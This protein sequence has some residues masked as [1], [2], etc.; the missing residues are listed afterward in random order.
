EA[1]ISQR[2]GVARADEKK[3]LHISP[4]AS[5]VSESDLQIFSA[6]LSTP[7]AS[8]TKYVP[9]VR[10]AT[11]TA[12]PSNVVE[13]LGTTDLPE[14]WACYLAF[15][16]VFM[17]ES[18]FKSIKPEEREAL[19]TWV[20]TGGWLTL[21]GSTEPK[22]ETLMLG[23]LQRQVENPLHQKMTENANGWMKNQVLWKSKVNEGAGMPY[24]IKKGQ[25]TT[26]ALVVAAIFC[27]VAGPGNYLYCRRKKSIHLLLYTLPSLSILFCLLIAAQFVLSK[28]L[29]RTG[30]SV[31][32]TL[33]DEA[34]N[35]GITLSKH[36]FYSG[37]YPLRGFH[38]NAQTAL[39]FPHP[40]EERSRGYGNKRSF[41]MDVS[42][43]QH[44]KNGLFVPNTTFDYMTVL[45][46]KTRE[47][48]VL[49]EAALTVMNGFEKVITQLL[50]KVGDQY[51]E[52]RD[53]Q[54]GAK[55]TLTSY[56][57]T[58]GADPSLCQKFAKAFLDQAG[59]QYLRDQEKF[60]SPTFSSS[61]VQ[62]M[63]QLSAPLASAE[64]GIVFSA[65][66]K[67][68]NLLIGSIG[69]TK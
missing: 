48:L 18:T 58:A 8:T 31:S 27:I 56:T 53:I 50:L 63:M 20:R 61:R 42:Q 67:T 9:G 52:A 36:V 6:G 29:S 32:L 69:E 28:G 41:V 24:P 17:N 15:N 35:S 30:N 11:S 34:T 62:Y 3:I 66:S 12:T 59:S 44:L 13:Q 49:D 65:G 22:K 4:T 1:G 5:R 14:N 19:L 57:P 21:Y 38:F 64:P 45:P 43:D 37:L 7:P 39:Y 33:L 47:R 68:C 46:F 2:H 26:S 23:T 16:A 54:P 25:G 51:Y 55:V 10:P 60:C 40:D